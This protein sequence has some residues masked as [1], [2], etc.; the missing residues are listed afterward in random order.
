MSKSK[1]QQ[2]YQRCITRHADR[3]NEIASMYYNILKRN[4]G[5]DHPITIPITYVK[6]FL[7]TGQ[8]AH[9]GASERMK[10]QAITFANSGFL[11]MDDQVLIRES[12]HEWLQVAFHYLR[13]VGIIEDAGRGVY[14]LIKDGPV[15]LLDESAVWVKKNKKKEEIILD[16]TSVVTVIPSN[17]GKFVFVE[18][19]DEKIQP[20]VEE[21]KKE[22]K[23]EDSKYQPILIPYGNN[24]KQAEEDLEAEVRLE[25]V[26]K[27]IPTHI[28]NSLIDMKHGV[29]NAVDL[30]KKKVSSLKVQLQELAKIVVVQREQLKEKDKIIEEK[31]EEIEERNEELKDFQ[32]L[33]TWLKELGE[34]IEGL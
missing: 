30:F 29:S 8:I 1:N 2:D 20:K 5:G 19:M 25:Q 33:P 22:E 13:N 4:D 34:E 16:N 27:E 26:T 14:R 31:C 18:V 9:K 10:E 32:Q 6:E 28:V 17:V 12:S 15:P 7:T 24:L 23:K 11:T 3:I 21:K